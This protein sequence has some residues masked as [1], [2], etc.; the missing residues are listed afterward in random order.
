MNDIATTNTELMTQTAVK[1]LENMG[2]LK[3]MKEPQKEQFIE[4]CVLYGLNPFKRE[5]Y[6]V[7]YG[8]GFNIIVGYE[9]YLKRAERSGKLDGWEVE[10]TGTGADLAATVTIYRKDWRQPFKHTARLTEFSGRGPLW[11]KSPAFMLGKVAVSQGFR[12]AFP[13]ELGGIPY[14]DEETDTFSTPKKKTGET[15]YM[16][17]DSDD[18]QAGLITDLKALHSQ[19]ANDF[20]AGKYTAEEITA[21][22]Q[23]WLGVDKTMDCTDADKVAKA[24]IAYDAFRQTDLEEIIESLV[25]QAY[26]PAAITRAKNKYAE[27]R[28]VFYFHLLDKISA[29][30]DDDLTLTQAEVESV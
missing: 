23:R 30:A 3:K 26:H 4:I 13:D 22:N 6:A 11:Q 12:M 9:V 7:P 16:Q 18:P 17:V 28:V 10:T 25:T 20:K 1:W 29:K 27:N 24:V 2:F 21:W 5:I 14:S 15:E 19:Q 8:E